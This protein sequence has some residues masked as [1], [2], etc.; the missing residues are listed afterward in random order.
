[1][2]LKLAAALAEARR[3]LKRTSSTTRGGTQT[4]AGVGTGSWTWTPILSAWPDIADQTVRVS[5]KAGHSSEDGT[6]TLDYR[7]RLRG[8]ERHKRKA[9]PDWSRLYM[10]RALNYQGS[11]KD[12]VAR[13]HLQGKV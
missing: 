11:V 13:R 6:L 1:M 9:P 8:L 10:I 12:W 5:T 7:L 4:R 2:D 3:P